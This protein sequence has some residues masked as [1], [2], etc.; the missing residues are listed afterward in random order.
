MSI[1]IIKHGM[2][3]SIQD[4]GRYGYQHLGINPNGTMDFIAAQTANILVGNDLNEAV[5]ECHFPASVF[6][7][8]F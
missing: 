5:I 1:R 4:L 2:A 8:I 6:L 7:P 3:D